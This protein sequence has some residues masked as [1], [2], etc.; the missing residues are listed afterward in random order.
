MHEGRYQTL[1]SWWALLLDLRRR[2]LGVPV[3]GGGSSL[4]EGGQPAWGVACLM[5]GQ[6]AQEVCGVPTLV[7][8]NERSPITLYNPSNVLFAA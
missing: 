8:G 1:H 5:G 2:S 6:P 3:L 4:P 7:E